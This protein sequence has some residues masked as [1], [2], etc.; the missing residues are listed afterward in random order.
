MTEEQFNIISDCLDEFDFDRVHSVMFHLNWVYSETGD[1]PTLQ[2]LRKK[3]RLNLIDAIANATKNNG[4]VYTI[5]TGG[6]RY[7]A[8]VSEGNTWVRTAF[9]VTDWDNYE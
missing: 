7:E 3:V 2:H 6:F 9:E 4:N 8:Q 1:V 5:S